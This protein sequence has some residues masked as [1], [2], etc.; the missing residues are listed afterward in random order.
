MLIFLKHLF[1]ETSA[2]G[3]AAICAEIELR[4][5][6]NS[7][8]WAEFSS[9]RE[10]VSEANCEI[11]PIMPAL[12]RGPSLHRTRSFRAYAGLHVSAASEP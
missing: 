3:A 9:L 7:A 11:K 1:P 2:P 12:R 5:R 4:E 8:V 10:S 6:D